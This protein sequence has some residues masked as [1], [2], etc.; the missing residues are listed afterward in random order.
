MTGEST[1]PQVNKLKALSV[2]D[3][4]VV[5]GGALVLVFGLFHWFSWEIDNA[6]VRGEGK[7]NAFD[8]FVTGFVPWLLVV[9]AAVVTLL[10]ATEALTAAA[11][12][13]TDPARSHRAGVS[14]SSSSA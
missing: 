4:L 9:G 7:S 8:Y 2:G 11:S 6:G 5:A 14:C 3:W 10:L 12:L 13:G 1:V